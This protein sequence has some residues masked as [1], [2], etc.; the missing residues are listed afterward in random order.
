MAD[1]I[2]ITTHNPTKSPKSNLKSKKR[3][4]N[5]NSTACSS[6]SSSSSMAVCGT[7]KERG[8]R[9][10]SVKRKPRFLVRRRVNDVEAIAFPLGM[11]IA[12]VVAQVL[13]QQA[14][15]SNKMSAEHL[16]RIC[17]SA[18]RESLA[19]VFG[20]KFEDFVA[21]FEK[22]F[23][24][25][26]STLRLIR[27]STKKEADEVNLLSYQSHSSG[28]PLSITEDTERTS[29]KTLHVDAPTEA[30]Y[31]AINNQEQLT[32]TVVVQVGDQSHTM[33]QEL[34]VHRQ[35]GRQLT[36]SSSDACNNF[37]DASDFTNVSV[38][39]TWK[40]SVAE[41]TRANDLK[42]FEI[43]LIMK[44]LQLK[45]TQLALNSDS[46]FL[47]RCKLFIGT[48]KASFRAE[49][50]K[51]HLEE[52]RHAELLR[53]C[54]DCLVAGLLIMSASVMYATYVFSYKRIA[55]ATSS[56][57]DLVGSKS[58]WFPKPM[59]SLTS[60]MQSLRCQ[61]LVLSRMLFG[62]LMIL[63]VAYLLL[64][65]AAAAPNQT[66]PITFILL[67]LGTA[68][69]YAGKLCLETLGGSGYH[70]L[71][72][73][74]ILCAIHFFANICTP[75]LFDILHGPVRPSQGM[76]NRVMFPYRLRRILFYLVVLVVLPLLCGL[77]PFAS[78]REWREHFFSSAI[79]ETLQGTHD[80]F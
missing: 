4:P 10:N 54:I 77:M 75:I 3:D 45:E 13:E 27:D 43:G 60:G 5:P 25:T 51:N 28:G 61:V 57:S 65:R 18:V 33:G 47:E 72:H 12:A 59:A 29:S 49:K 37:G 55:E 30:S 50:F 22:S 58:S 56:C 21:I 52:T 73:W 53:K 71:V 31:E 69:G 2:S 46:N 68:C 14:A 1:D 6:S 70:W 67:L 19:N 24:S 42:T 79:P 34:F 23:G 44:K 20:D 26:L 76:Q 74:E 48:S 9:V 7:S 16:S 62:F 63:A 35:I 64:Q 11:S 80:E 15:T 17:T 36:S 40:N 78:I 66:M 41:Q 8:L 38:F 39:N 32:N